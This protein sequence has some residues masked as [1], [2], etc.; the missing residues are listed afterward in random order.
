MGRKVES[1][2]QLPGEASLVS[3][4]RSDSRMK[5]WGDHLNVLTHSLLE[6]LYAD[7]LQVFLWAEEVNVVY[8][9]SSTC[10]ERPKLP[11]PAT[12]G[13]LSLALKFWR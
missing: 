10:S 11:H 8:R 9:S 6:Q 7:F 2:D 4:S 3:C 5:G 12:A 13:S 1:A